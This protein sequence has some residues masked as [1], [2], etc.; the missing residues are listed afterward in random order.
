MP[1][2]SGCPDLDEAGLSQECHELGRR[3]ERAD[4]R[5]QVGIRRR[6]TRN[7]PADEW[8]DMTEVPQIERTHAWVAGTKLENRETSAGTQHASHLRARHRRALDVPNPK[9]DRYRIDDAIAGGIRIASPRT[10]A[11]IA[12]CPALNFA[13]RRAASPPRNRRRRHAP[14]PA[15]SAGTSAVP[16]HTSISVRGRSA[17]RIARFRQRRSIPALSR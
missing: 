11:T 4:R 10:R 16:V 3:R 5:R 12:C 15:S 13:G 14:R 1:K 6:V 9:R 2:V 8:Q 7:H 17:K